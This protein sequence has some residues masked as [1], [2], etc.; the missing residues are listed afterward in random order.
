MNL[1][2][3]KQISVDSPVTIVLSELDGISYN[4]GWETMRGF[5]GEHFIPD[6][7]YD[8]HR[9]ATPCGNDMRLTSPPTSVESLELLQPDLTD[10]HKFDSSNH[11][12]SSMYG[13]T[14]TEAQLTRKHSW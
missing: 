4:K 1:A 3:A 12:P 10:S 14:H 9:R 7:P 13:H 2:N 8:K 5:L 11:L 6:G